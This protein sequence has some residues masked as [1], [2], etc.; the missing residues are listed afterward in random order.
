MEPVDDKYKPKSRLQGLQFLPGE[1]GRLE[2]RYLDTFSYNTHWDLQ[3]AWQDKTYRENLPRL[4]R[5]EISPVALYMLLYD[6]NDAE[7]ALRTGLSRRKVRKHRSGRGFARASVAE[8]LRY[9]EVWGVPL[10]AFFC[11][12]DPD[13]PSLPVQVE[14]SSDGR[15]VFLR[16]DHDA[17][18]WNFL[19]APT[20]RSL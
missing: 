14:E 3:T 4:L 17:H 7:V 12:A 18:A 8:L 15:V 1:E 16:Q 10:A 19:R 9:A 2:G 6:M 11:F 20:R 13:I 5:G